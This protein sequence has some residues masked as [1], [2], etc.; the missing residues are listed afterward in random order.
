MSNFDHKL[1]KYAELAIKV[2]INLK[3]KEGLLIGGNTETLP[4][5]RLVMKKAYEAGAKHV[6]FQ[7]SDDEMSLIRFKYGKDYV[8]DNFPQWKVDSLEAMYKDN[9]H[10]LFISA[11]DPEL[12]KDIDS[13]LVARSQKSASLA[14]SPIMKYRMTG[15]TKWSIIAMPSA[16]WAKS[17]FPDLEEKAAME[18]LW[19]KIFEA[20]RIDQEDPIK[21]WQIHDS[22]L[23]KYRNFLNEKQ[24]EKLVFQSPGTDL[25]VYLADD[26]FWMGGSKE[27]ENGDPF[28]A[29]IPTEEVFT[30][31]HYLK[32]NGTLKA[33]KPLSLNGKLVDDFG[34][35]FKDGKVVD[36]YAEKGYEVL[37][38]LMENDEGA[39]YLGEVALVE[40][41]SPIS[42]TGILF[43]NTLFDENAS[44]HFA[45]GRAYP[46]TMKNGSEMTQEELTAKGANFSLIHVDFMVGGT[47]LNIT[48]YEKNGNKVELFRNGNWDL[49]LG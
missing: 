49:S 39:K 17:V 44:V 3:E 24:F 38:K 10:H 37:A 30:T 12:L 21:A 2:G 6:E 29:N 41:N 20:T 14:A 47:E 45:L 48:A 31:P 40:N 13:D 16:A 11:P 32:V 25:E 19:K 43:N 18:N 22:N 28:V 5:A 7:L 33:T 46:Y 15:I 9:Y 4:L 8:F 36:F 26:H 42:N 34:F 23:K 1:E 35:T 27:S